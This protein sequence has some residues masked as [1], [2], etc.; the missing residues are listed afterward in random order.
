MWC[1]RPS[2]TSP[3]PNYPQ[4][5]SSIRELLKATTRWHGS[6]PR[7]RASPNH[8]LRFCE[9][10][11]A[12]PTLLLLL[13]SQITTSLLKKASASWFRKRSRR[14]DSWGVRLAHASECTSG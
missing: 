6:T 11:N 3:H 5:C 7:E 12:Q 1:F 10:R 8:S 2:H 13:G 4:E 14:A 9:Q